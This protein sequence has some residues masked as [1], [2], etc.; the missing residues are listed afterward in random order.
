MIIA[1]GK[2]REF[3]VVIARCETCEFLNEEVTPCECAKGRG[4]VAYRHKACEKYQSKKEAKNNA[5]H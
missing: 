1:E 4:R 2:K 5:A 3:V